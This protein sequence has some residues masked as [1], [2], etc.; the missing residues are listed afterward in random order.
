MKLTDPE[1][2]ITAT[3]NDATGDAFLRDFQQR[4]RLTEQEA[5]LWNSKAIRLECE[6]IRL[7]RCEE[8]LNLMNFIAG[9]FRFIESRC[10]AEMHR[11]Y[12]VEWNGRTFSKKISDYDRMNDREWPLRFAKEAKAFFAS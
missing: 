11:E 4:L 3:S 7:K 10:D 12:I 8:T 9:P 1:S 5:K 6:N 2:G